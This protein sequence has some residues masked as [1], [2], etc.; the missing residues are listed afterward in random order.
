MWI[1]NR[2]DGGNLQGRIWDSTR[3][4]E[5]KVITPFTNNAECHTQMEFAIAT[6]DGF[7]V[8]DGTSGV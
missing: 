5:N 6:T 7:T 3:G 1:R 2:T 8:E 4:F